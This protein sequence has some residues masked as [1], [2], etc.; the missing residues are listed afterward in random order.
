MA[1]HK[2]AIFDWNGTLL[3]DIGPVFGSVCAIFD[4]YGVQRP[5]LDEYRNEIGSDFM[6]FYWKHGIPSHVTG[7]ELNVIRKAYLEAHLEEATLHP[8]VREVLALASTLGMYRGIVSGEID[9]LLVENL[10]RFD[11][12]GS[13]QS[14]CGGVRNKKEKLLDLCNVFEVH[15]SEAF[16]LD[17]TF[18]GIMAAKKAGLFVIGVTHGYAS[19]ERIAAAEPDHTCDSLEALITFLKAEQ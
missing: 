14:I 10:V 16:Y 15:P 18:E 19:P 13:L 9:K 17:D 4:A 6:P 3:N 11:L 12:F 1:K 5:T 7:A 2:F 8:N